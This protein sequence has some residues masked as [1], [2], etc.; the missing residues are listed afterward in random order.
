MDEGTL[1][2]VVEYRDVW[3]RI[4]SGQA[5]ALEEVG[6]RNKL[7][8]LGA[9]LEAGV[10]QKIESGLYDRLDPEEGDILFLSANPIGTTPLALQKEADTIGTELKSGTHPLTVLPRLAGVNDLGKSILQLKPRIVHFSGHG[11]RAGDFALEQTDGTAFEVTGGAVA[12]LMVEQSWN[13]DLVFLNACWSEEAAAP[14]QT[15]ADWIIGTDAA[16]GDEEAIQFSAG[17]YRGL[18]HGKQVPE[19]FNWAVGEMKLR[20]LDASNFKL[21]RGNKPLKA[22][23][24][25]VSPEFRT[26]V[27]RTA[28][29]TRSTETPAAES[30]DREAKSYPLWFGTDRTPLNSQDLSKG[31]GSERDQRVW[32]GTVKVTIPESHR[33]GEVGS[34]WLKRLITGDDRLKIERETLG[35]LTAEAFWD[36]LRN[37]IAEH[38]FSGESDPA[39]MVYVHGYNVSFDEAAIRAAQIGCDLNLPGP[40]AFYSWPSKGTLT[41]YMADSNTV[42]GSA[43]HFTDFLRAFIVEVAPHVKKIHLLAHSMGNRIAL[44]AAQELNRE[45]GKPVFD[46]II[47]AAADVDRMRFEQLCGAYKQIA[48]R[49]TLYIS[50]KDR[51]LMAS[52]IF[53]DSDR[54]GYFDPVTIVEGIDT[55]RAHRISQG[56]LG[57]GYYS[58]ARELLNDIHQLL[59][60]NAHPKDRSTIVKVAIQGKM[61]WELMA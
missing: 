47:L 44:D 26:E 30:T 38:V 10:I 11:S 15:T 58:E 32:L 14:F 27:E 54:A 55:V 19:A 7:I 41:G 53:N 2:T 33:I 8:R 40:M 42:L 59:R 28:Q 20:R 31:F 57:H 36:G 46:Q 51:A 50:D 6:L 39:A 37:Q 4:R 5:S 35:I 49:T 56:L 23:D 48:K 60:W 29:S 34:S 16:I 1:K 22:S 61:C 3:Q 13:L 21:L 18:A 25:V 9:K 45:L 43:K 24:K 52:E 12:G 17:F